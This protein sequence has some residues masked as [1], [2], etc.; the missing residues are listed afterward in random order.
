MASLGPSEDPV[1]QLLY[2]I[3]A[4]EILETR[5]F[6]VH[7]VNVHHLK[8]V[9]GRKTDV[10]DCRWIQYLHACGLLSAPF[11]PEAEMCALRAYL[12]HRATPVVMGSSAHS[13]VSRS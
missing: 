7:R 4:Y 13:R 6:Q 8:H 2:G 10:K 1:E 3:P 9:P 5:G 11:R 12:R